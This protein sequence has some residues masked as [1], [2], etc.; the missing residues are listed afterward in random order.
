MATTPEACAQ[1]GRTDARLTLTSRGPMCPS[2]RKALVASHRASAA[3]DETPQHWRARRVTDRHGG[4]LGRRERAWD[5]GRGRRARRTRRRDHRSQLSAAHLTRS[6]LSLSVIRYDRDPR[7]LRARPRRAVG[8]AGHL[9][10]GLGRRRR[11]PPT[12]GTA[13]DLAGGLHHINEAPGL[14]RRSYAHVLPE[15]GFE[16]VVRV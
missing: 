9:A 11:W 6:A 8:W 12:P 16:F 2:C 3:E 4:C 14:G 10:V 7:R 1:C 5:L 13:R 15:P